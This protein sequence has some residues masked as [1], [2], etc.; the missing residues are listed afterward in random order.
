M[1]NEYNNTLFEL[2][3]AMFCNTNPV[4]VKYALY[5]MGIINSPEVR[6]PLIEL[7][8]QQK[9]FVDL[10]IDKYKQI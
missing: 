9:T 6:L 8:D 7:N 1:K 5:K 4:P 3:K 2:S 10:I